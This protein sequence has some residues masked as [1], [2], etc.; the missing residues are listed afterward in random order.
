MSVCGIIAV[1]KSFQNWLAP[2]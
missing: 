1:G 2:V